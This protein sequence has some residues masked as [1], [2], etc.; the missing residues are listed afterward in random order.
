[1]QISARPPAVT[2]P[3]DR[4]TEKV[5]TADGGGSAAPLVRLAS[6]GLYPGSTRLRSVRSDSAPLGVVGARRLP[7]RALH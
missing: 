4:S 6:L 3:T 1:M 7:R 5:K 2:A